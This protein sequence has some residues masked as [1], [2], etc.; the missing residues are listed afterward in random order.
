MTLNPHENLVL[1]LL[2]HLLTLIIQLFQFTGDSPGFLY[3][4]GEEKLDGPSGMMEPA[5]GIE[6]GGKLECDLA[7]V[8][9]FVIEV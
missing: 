8:D 2:L 6:A 7:G 1:D 4:V 3:G 9:D 5:T